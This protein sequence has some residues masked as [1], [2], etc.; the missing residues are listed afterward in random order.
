MKF[1]TSRNSIGLLVLAHD[2]LLNSSQR[3]DFYLIQSLFT[4]PSE[5]ATG[6]EFSTDAKSLQKKKKKKKEKTTTFL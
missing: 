5:A 3:V 4:Q 6:I 2:P 1:P